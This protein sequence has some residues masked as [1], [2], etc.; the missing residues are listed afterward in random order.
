MIWPGTIVE[1]PETV[2]VTL[3][4]LE[5]MSPQHLYELAWTTGVA[6]QKWDSAECIREKLLGA[7]VI[8]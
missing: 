4:N 8:D 5:A 7:H 6:V 1:A 3:A 2:E